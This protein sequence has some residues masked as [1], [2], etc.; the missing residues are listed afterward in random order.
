[1]QETKLTNFFVGNTLKITQSPHGKYQN[2]QSMDFVPE[3]GRNKRIIAP[4]DGT[5][6]K[7]YD[8][9]HQRFF[10]FSCKDWRIIFVHCYPTV[11]GN[12][13]RGDHIGYL[14]EGGAI[15]AHVGLELGIGKGNWRKVLDYM[16]RSVKLQWAY[17]TPPST[18]DWANYDGVYKKDYKSPDGVFHA[19]GSRIYDNRTL[20]TCGSVVNSE[21]KPT[22][23][24]EP[25]DPCKQYKDELVTLKTNLGVLESEKEALKLQLADKDKEIDKLDEELEACR[26]RVDELQVYSEKLESDI[27]NLKKNS[28]NGFKDSF[29]YQLYLLFNKSGQN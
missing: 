22:T 29:F 13:K 12:V 21:N 9:G 5:V 28:N 15:H 7:V 10:Y 26:V 18:A 20:V 27:E 1:M 6:S 11:T 4:A 2:Y 19:K 25:V 3:D 23:P 14:A 24:P 17:A 8:S 16:D